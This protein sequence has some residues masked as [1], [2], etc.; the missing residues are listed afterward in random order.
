[1]GLRGPRARPAQR[2]A[3]KRRRRPTWA[4]K[5]LTRAEAV[6]RFCESLRVTSGM[7]AG[8]PLVLRPWQR[9]ILEAWYRCDAD[10]QRIVRTGLLTMGRKNGKTA[11]VSALALAHLVGPEREPRGQVIAA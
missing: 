2:T 8:R 4:K 1:M 3:T 11:L 10:G 5:G 6:L 7:H 9:E